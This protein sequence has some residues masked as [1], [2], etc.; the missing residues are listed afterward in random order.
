M[1][2]RDTVSCLQTEYLEAHGILDLDSAN[3][4]SK[5]LSLHQSPL[6][7]TCGDD[8]GDD[9]GARMMNQYRR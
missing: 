8:D 4:E 2:L 9:D 7:G 6:G 3:W 5:L 1:S